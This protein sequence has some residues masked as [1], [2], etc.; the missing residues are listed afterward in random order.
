MLLGVA[1]ASPVSAQSLEATIRSFAAAWGQEDER[2]LEGLVAPAIRLSID[3]AEHTGVAPAQVSAS[4][5]RLFSQY[6]SRVPDIT[7]QGVV[8]DAPDRGFAELTWAP[9]PV[10]DRE[11]DRHLLFVA[12]R[13]LPDGW[14]VIEL[15]ILR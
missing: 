1:A 8:Q 10:G 11:P 2:A 14:R 9:L 3:G 7:R 15:R 5:D 4:L 12:F 6:D 13:R